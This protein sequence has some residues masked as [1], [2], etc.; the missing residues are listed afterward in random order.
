MSKMRWYHLVAVILFSALAAC[1]QTGEHKRD[2]LWDMD[3]EF[4]STLDKVP[5][6]QLGAPFVKVGIKELQQHNYIAAQAGFNRALKF[7]PKNSQLHFL[8]GLTY[9]LRAADGDTS[10]EEYAAIG[11]ELA[12]QYDPAN[13]WAAYQIGQLN[14]ADQHYRKAQDAFAYALLF[15]PEE[16][17]LINA[18][19][20]ASYYAQDLETAA[21]AIRKA[22][23]ISPG[24]GNVLRLASL[25]DA[26]RGDIDGAGAYLARYREQLP[27]AE[28][29]RANYLQRRVKD[30]ERFHL[31]SR[32]DLAQTDT[33]ADINYG[34]NTDDDDDSDTPKPTTSDILGKDNARI[35]LN[36]SSL[37]DTDAADEDIEGQGFFATEDGGDAKSGDGRAMT[38]RMAMVDVV[39][40]HAEERRSTNKGVN[41]LSGLTATLAGT[42]FSLDSTR[43]VNDAGTGA[44]T[45][46]NT[47]TY[48]PTL[49]VAATYSLNILNDNNDHSE[50]LARPSLIALDKKKSEFFTGSILHVQLT[51]VA[52]SEGTVAD[53]PVGIRLS[54]TPVFLS[55]NK[56]EL[57][58]DAAR[59]F[60]ENRSA[61]IGFSNFAQITKTEVT[62]HVIME[63]GDTLILSGLS[64]KESEKLN[65]GV[66]ILQDIPGL[67]YFF[68]HEDTLDFSK[69]VLILLTPRKP[70]Y[71]YKD[72]SSKADRSNP[73]DARVKQPNLSELKSRPDWIRPAANM[74]GVFE[75]FK[76]YRFFKE[77]RAG[78]VT[79][80]KWDN[81]RDLSERIKRAIDF[82][83]F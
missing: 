7:D 22:E 69:S 41:L 52:G 53:V 34:D 33:G 8:N 80:E 2:A 82:L 62:A 3:Q 25:V 50:V 18:L 56:I 17:A 76:T 51:G 75:H 66:P 9:H 58:V 6:E 78:D 36:P 43:T 61:Q 5:G 63:F 35:G 31:R 40:I 71:T 68:S 77:F 39:I 27:E 11:Y 59:A 64:E 16:P 20:T 67:Q 72:G 57:N 55:D 13:Y 21:I 70:Q 14:F 10:H 29:R 54:V 65:D 45:L 79:L 74:D 4:L 38:R 60:L 24:D 47:F 28:K 1:A 44:N 15:A 30:W 73:D 83:Y 19:A 42:T 12:L 48:A 46:V 81:P 23:A 37:D 49:S 32:I 26:A